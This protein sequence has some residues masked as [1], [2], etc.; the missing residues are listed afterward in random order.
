MVPF[1]WDNGA[2]LDRRFDTV[3]EP[4]LQAALWRGLHAASS[5]Q[6]AGSETV[7]TPSSLKET[8]V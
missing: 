1:Y 7:A 6:G 4:S 5:M 8:L 2:L 3:R